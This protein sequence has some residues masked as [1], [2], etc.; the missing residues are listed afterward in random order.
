VSI[1]ESV[2]QSV[3]DGLASLQRPDPFAN[4]PSLCV[5]ARDGDLQPA[6]SN[7]TSYA[8]AASPVST[9]HQIAFRRKMKQGGQAS[10]NLLLAMTFSFWQL[11]ADYCPQLS[12]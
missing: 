2:K 1:S 6:R 3:Q 10:Q 12:R 5:I 4:K 9:L 11:T 8:A 7:P